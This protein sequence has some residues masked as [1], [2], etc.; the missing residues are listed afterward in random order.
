MNFEKKKVNFSKLFRPNKTKRS[1]KGELIFVLKHK[2]TK[3][4]KMINRM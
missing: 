3:I 2:Y 4:N 1:F